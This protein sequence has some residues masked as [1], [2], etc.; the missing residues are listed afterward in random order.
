M[1]LW[2]KDAARHTKNQTVNQLET[3][4]YGTLKSEAE[5]SKYDVVLETRH[6]TEV[7]WST[8]LFG[9]A[10]VTSRMI[11]RLFGIDVGIIILYIHITQKHQGGD[12][13]L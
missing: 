7:G 1:K 2:L 10:K 11:T 13:V 4:F 3:G 8:C 12:S 9:D 5:F 6:D